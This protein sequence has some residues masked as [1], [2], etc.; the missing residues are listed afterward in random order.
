MKHQVES[1]YEVEHCGPVAHGFIVMYL[2]DYMDK[3]MSLV[4]PVYVWSRIVKAN[5][6]LRPSIKIRELIDV[7]GSKIEI[8]YR[9]KVDNH[10]HWNIKEAIVNFGR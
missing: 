10:L 1:L 3:K 2:Q 7:Y 9:K 4:I 6:M 8:M 5:K